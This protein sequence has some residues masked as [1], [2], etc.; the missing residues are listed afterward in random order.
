MG[1]STCEANFAASSRIASTV[2]GP[3]SSKPGNPAT[4]GKSASSLRTKFMS[5]SGAVYWLMMCGCSQRYARNS[6]VCPLGCEISF[7]PGDWG[8]RAVPLILSPGCL[9]CVPPPDRRKIHGTEFRHLVWPA[10]TVPANSALLGV[11]PLRYDIVVPQQHPIERFGGRDQL[12]ASLGEDHTI[13]QRIDGWFLDSCEIARAGP[14]SGFRAPEPSLF[15]SGRQRLG[16]RG[17]DNVKIEPPQPVLVL[18]LIHRS[19]RCIDAEPLERRLVEQGDAFIL[20]G[21]DQKLDRQRFA[22]LAIDENLIAYPVPRL[23]QQARCMAQIGTNCFRAAADRILEGRLKHF[24]RNLVAHTIK[25]LEFKALRYIGCGKLG[26][27]EKARDSRVLPKEKLSVHF[28]EIECQV[29]RL[30]HPRVFELI[31][32]QV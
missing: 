3:A 8:V 12:L 7:K 5:R 23:P 25:D 19:H 6:E 1:A 31:S 22:S 16:P 30:P 32:P 26:A 20:G 27:L 24:G 11:G 2:S 18:R 14:V 9:V 29:E 21:S 10:E 15:V 17:D 4:C 28:L 13:D